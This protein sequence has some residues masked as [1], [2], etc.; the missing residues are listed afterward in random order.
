MSAVHSRVGLAAGRAEH[1]CVWALLDLRESM[2]TSWTVVI[3]PSSG[4]LI[5]RL[6]LRLCSFIRILRP[7]ATPPL[8]VFS[9][10]CPMARANACSGSKDFPCAAAGCLSLGKSWYFLSG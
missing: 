10:L 6:R 1:A 3:G 8:S 7:L 2:A 4:T 5:L 9:P